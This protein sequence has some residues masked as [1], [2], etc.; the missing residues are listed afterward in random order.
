MIDLTANNALVCAVMND[1]DGAFVFAQQ[2]LTYGNEKY[3][4]MGVSTSGN[5]EN[6][7][8]ALKTARAMKMTTIGMTG[9]S[10][11]RIGQLCDILLNVPETETC[12]IQ[13]RHMSLYHQICY[14]VEDL[15][16]ES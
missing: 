9:K 14:Q 12:R 8:R 2:V 1:M 7:R 16:F 3:I 10:G 11:G 15:L 13:E 6:V 4:L 5:A